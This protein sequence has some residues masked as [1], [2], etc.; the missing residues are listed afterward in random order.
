[1]QSGSKDKRESVGDAL[2]VAAVGFTVNEALTAMANS[3]R[4]TAH[5][6]DAVC[7]SLR[8]QCRTNVEDTPTQSPPVQAYGGRECGGLEQR[9][10]EQ[11]QPFP[12]LDSEVR[13]GVD[14][15]TAAFHLSRKEQTLRAWACHQ[16]GPI[17]P[18]RINGRLAWP[19]VE[20]RRVLARSSDH[21]RPSTWD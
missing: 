20:L 17:R 15:R 10:E 18:L 9:S 6:I 13:I 12:P 4:M 16:D 14:T 3:L 5:A 19:V 2:A 7:G 11:S 1:M 8:T 21:G